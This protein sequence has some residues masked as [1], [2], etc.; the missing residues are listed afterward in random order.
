M[1][2]KLETMRHDTSHHRACP[3][4]WRRGYWIWL[5][6]FIC[7]ILVPLSRAN[8]IQKKAIAQD[9]ACANGLNTITVTLQVMQDCGVHSAVCA[10]LVCA[11]IT[12]L[13]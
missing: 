1:L 9:N 13:T 8:E 6:A 5:V 7:A 10:V 3:P 4:E 11:G 2:D 12:R